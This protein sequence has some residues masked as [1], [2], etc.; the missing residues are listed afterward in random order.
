MLLEAIDTEGVL[1]VDAAGARDTKGTASTSSSVAL[2]KVGSGPTPPKFDRSEFQ[3]PTI[4][5]LRA[6]GIGV[7]TV[8]GKLDMLVYCLLK[9][10]CPHCK[11]ALISANSV[12]K[13]KLCYAVPWPK[14]IVWVDMRCGKCNKH[15]MTHDVNYVSTLPS[16]QQVQREFVSGKG[17]GCHISLL[18][19][20]RSGL[21]VAQVEQYV[22]D[23]VR[24]HYLKLKS[25]YVELWDKVFFLFCLFSFLLR[26]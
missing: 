7:K 15:F 5:E 12:G 21:T 17:N 3:S 4:G 10:R 25:N 13:R 26:C 24:Q 9:G 23:D 8:S 2:P 14:T 16:H 6:M 11:S 1:P 22:E 19:M 20:L 18:R